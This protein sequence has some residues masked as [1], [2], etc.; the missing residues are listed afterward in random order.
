MTE[1]TGSSPLSNTRPAPYTMSIEFLL[2]ASLLLSWGFPLNHKLWPLH[3]ST[4]N[5]SYKNYSLPHSLKPAYLQYILPA[6]LSH[7]QILLLLSLIISPINIHVSPPFSHIS[8]KPTSRTYSQLP[9]LV[10]DS[11]PLSSSLLRLRQILH[12]VSPLVFTHWFPGLILATL[13]D[14]PTLLMPVT[15]RPFP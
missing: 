11:A 3:S 13:H 15:R 8:Q 5:L 12:H 10:L 14:P 2:R 1:S 4:H 7:I 9:Q 6:P